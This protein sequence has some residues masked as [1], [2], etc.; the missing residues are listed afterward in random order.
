MKQPRRRTWPWLLLLVFI[1][2]AVQF[3]RW[4][5]GWA[6]AIAFGRLW[7]PNP[8]LETRIAKDGPY[9][10]PDPATFYGGGEAGYTDYPA[11]EDEAATV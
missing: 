3:A 1:G 9:R 5:S 4:P 2:V 7:I 11:F 10:E 8:D 6:D